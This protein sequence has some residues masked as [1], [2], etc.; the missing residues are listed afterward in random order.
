MANFYGSQYNSAYVAN[1]TSK[2]APGDYNGEIRSLFG[3]YLIPANHSSG[4]LI[5]IGK[6]PAGA[7]VINSIL[8]ASGDLGDGTSL[9]LGYLNNGVDADD[10]DAFI[11]GM[12]TTAAAISESVDAASNSGLFKKFTVET[13]VVVD[14]K[15]TLGVTDTAVGKTISVVIKYVVN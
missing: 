15:A 1:P 5:Y 13:E 7:R 4:D 9:D 12:A 6:L 2:I 10:K 8:L 14:L 11:D 3:S